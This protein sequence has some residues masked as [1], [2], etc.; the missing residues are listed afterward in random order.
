MIIDFMEQIEDTRKGF[1]ESFASG[2]FYNRQ[3]QDSDHMEKILRF[4]KIRGKMRVLDLGCGS[5]YLS[6]PMAKNNPDSEV[7]GLDIVSDTL[8]ANRSKAN[9]ERIKNLSFVR[10]DGIDFPFE[11]QSFDLVVARYALHHFP[12]IG[13]SIGEMSRVLKE[14]GKLFISDPCPNECDTER[15]VDDYMRLKKDGHIRFYSKDEWISLCGKRDLN[16]VDGFESSIRFPKKKDTAYGYKEVLAKHDKSVIKSYDLAE[17]DTE[18]FITEHVNNLLFRK[19]RPME[20][21]SDEG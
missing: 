14:G 20:G 18:L 13:H 9:E 11:D 2:E 10:Y 16:F 17:T 15:F 6:F 3:T 5:G 19:N 7:I 21:M 12:D 4:V 1:E 8:E